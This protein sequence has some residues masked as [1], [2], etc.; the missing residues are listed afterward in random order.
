M[1]VYLKD[2]ATMSAINNLR[3]NLS[4]CFFQKYFSLKEAS[5]NRVAD[6]LIKTTTITSIDLL[7]C[8]PQWNSIPEWQHFLKNFGRF[9]EQVI[10]R[11]PQITHASI[12]VLGHEREDEALRMLLQN[13]PNLKTL[14]ISGLHSFQEQFG[15]T[16]ACLEY[17]PSLR[18]I[19]MTRVLDCHAGIPSLERIPNLEA[20]ELSMLGHEPNASAIARILT[21]NLPNLVLEAKVLALDQEA[22]QLFNTAIIGARIQGIGLMYDNEFYDAVS[23]VHA[24]AGSQLKILQVSYIQFKQGSMSEFL[25]N[26]A[27]VLPSMLQLQNLVSGGFFDIELVNHRPAC[28]H[29]CT[30]VVQAVA[31]CHSLKYLKLNVLDCSESID[32]AL[33]KCFMTNVALAELV[34]VCPRHNS[35]KTA[36]LPL[37]ENVLKNNYS[38]QAFVTFQP[39]RKWNKDLQQRIQTQLKLNQAGRAYLTHDANNK[40]AAMDVLLQVIDSLD[41]LFWHLRENPLLCKTRASEFYRMQR[42][43]ASTKR[44]LQALQAAYDGLEAENARL[45][46]RVA[47]YEK[48]ASL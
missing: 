19:K 48:P 26:L 30:A 25:T 29:A 3:M 23:L 32:T 9:C 10:G 15:R 42:D 14:I 4:S 45:K 27:D 28:D 13:L 17:H 5:Q 31:K 38:L 11:M 12:S 22:Q 43:V 47:L 7:G 24:F 44:K 37:V 8:M 35:L 46:Q 20:I 16:I 41:C 36:A 33:A 2:L 39:T 18:T 6:A 21:A 1:K 34:L 40:H